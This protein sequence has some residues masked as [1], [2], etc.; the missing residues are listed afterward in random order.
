[1][2][3]QKTIPSAR[4][5]DR[6][7]SVALPADQ[8]V[9]FNREGRWSRQG[10]L[11]RYDEYA[12]RFRVADPLDVS[13]DESSQGNRRWVYPVMEKVIEGIER[14]DRACIEI[15]IEFIEEDELF[16]FGKILKSN[17]ARALRRANLTTEHEERIR[18][19]VSEMLMAG[20]VPH[21]FR[22]YA[23]LLRRVGLGDEWQK[24]EEGAPRG[25]PYVQRFLD[26]FRRH[27]SV[28]P[29]KPAKNPPVG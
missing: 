6:G 10:V 19:R 29:A 23:K 14:G 7:R 16:P 15:G 4:K 12:R 13:P 21:E 8:V 3:R 27:A 9:D 11:D 2:S 18:R 22:E 28:E 1:M 17:T 26:Y 5:K 25:N 24:V 20:H